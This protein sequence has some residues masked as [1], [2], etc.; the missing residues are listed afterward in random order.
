MHLYT[1]L[2]KTFAMADQPL[3]GNQSQATRRRSPLPR[4][5]AQRTRTLQFRKKRTS[6]R[7]EE[8]FWEYLDDLA[9]LKRSRLGPMIGELAQH[10]RGGN[11]TAHLR[12]ACLLDS[13]RRLAEEGPGAPG[14]SREETVRL[15]HLT[16]CPG[17]ILSAQASIL[18][19]NAAALGWLKRERADLLG[20]DFGALL[21]LQM[22]QSFAR[23]WEN[24]QAGEMEF[25]VRQALVLL[26]GRL[27]ATE[28]TFLRLT[29]T[30]DRPPA[31]VAWFAQPKAG[32]AAPVLKG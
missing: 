4:A 26:P 10:F 23:F 25:S 15:F 2:N 5:Y 14:G 3:S 16:P 1:V 27:T 11:L 6:V 7:L 20:S 9:A 30:E 18:D 24:L 32:A 13:L 12:A 17:L 19:C 29:Q 22:G 31:F 21:R 8:V 28:I